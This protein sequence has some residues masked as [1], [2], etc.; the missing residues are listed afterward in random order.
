MNSRKEDEVLEALWVCSEKNEYSIEDLCKRC[1]DAFDKKLLASLD[2]ADL[3]AH[4]GDMVLL[5][6]KGKE[7]AAGVVR[8]HRLAERLLAD[9]LKMPVHEAEESAC[10]FE[11]VLA[12]E[13]TESICTLLGHPRECPHGA[14][15]PEGRCC[16][17]A[18]HIIDNVVVSLDKLNVGEGAKVGLEQNEH[19][20]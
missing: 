2:E 5:T 7:R 17:D 8:R 3:I 16:A 10:E 18:I 20:G 9:V 19:H 12:P 14:P 13:V 11:H 15:I 4:D 1:E 6:R